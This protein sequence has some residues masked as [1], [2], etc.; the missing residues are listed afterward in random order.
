MKR[1]IGKV[2]FYKFVGGV[3]DEY[4]GCGINCFGG[5][6]EPPDGTVIIGSDDVD[7]EFDDTRRK[8]IEVLEAEISK[9]NLQH[10]RWLNMMNGKIQSLTAI[11][12]KSK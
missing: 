12:H 2:Y 4:I 1:Y 11:E 6:Y 3:M 5:D 10:Q 7:V 8:E 9:K